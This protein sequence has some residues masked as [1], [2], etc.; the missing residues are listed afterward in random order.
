MFTFLRYHLEFVELEKGNLPFSDIFI[1]L[2]M[3]LYHFMQI[4][5]YIP[6]NPQSSEDKRIS[7]K[8]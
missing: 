5:K 8:I 3:V 6:K 4:Y 1:R 2:L 7:E